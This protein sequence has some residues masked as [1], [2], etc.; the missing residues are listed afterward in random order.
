L[1]TTPKLH[2][3]FY[4]IGDARG[5]NNDAIYIENLRKLNGQLDHAAL[6]AAQEDDPMKDAV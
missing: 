2:E 6:T 5:I 1:P 3:D 4:A